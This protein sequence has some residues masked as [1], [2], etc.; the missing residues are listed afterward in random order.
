MRKKGNHSKET[1]T[2]WRARALT[3][4]NA[5]LFAQG[6]IDVPSPPIE[7]VAS[8]ICALTDWA[9]P[10]TREDQWK[11]VTRYATEI[12]GF[13][14]FSASAVVPLKSARA[15]RKIKGGAG[16]TAKALRVAF[17]ASDEWRRLR[18]R[19]LKEYG[20]KCM[21]CH[22]TDGV[23][24]VDHIKPRSKYPDLEL[25]FDNMQVLCEDCNLGKSAWDETDW[26]Q[27]PPSEH[28]ERLD[29]EYREIMRGEKLN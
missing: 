12:L 5:R 2:K 4:V 21:C 18:Y 22:K 3:C 27:P 14:L 15:S 16:T 11:T 28:A 26:R 24:H 9:V 23:M 8:T 25:V 1:P 13:R 10:Q 17:Y 20:R 7:R 6:K 19:V 29:E